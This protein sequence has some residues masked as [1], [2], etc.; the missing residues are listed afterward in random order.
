MM[1]LIQE[2]SFT[3]KANRQKLSAPTHVLFLF[4]ALTSSIVKAGTITVENGGVVQGSGTIVSDVIV[5]SGGSLNP[6]QS[7]GCLAMNNLDYSGGGTL[8]AEIGGDTA[9]TGYD[10]LRVTGTVALGAILD[11]SAYNS[12]VPVA[13]DSYQII[14]NDGADSVTGIFT[15]LEEGDV[16]T[17]SGKNLSISY[18]GGDGNDVVL[19]A[20]SDQTITFP[21]PAD[22]TYDVGSINVAATATSGLSVS[23]S[24]NSLSICSVSGST[25]SILNVGTCSITA[26]QS[27]NASYNAAVNVTQTFTVNKADQTISFGA[28]ANKTYGDA[29]FALGASSNSGLTVSFSSTTSSVCSVSGTTLS[30]VGAGSCSITASQEGDSNYNAATDVTQSFTINKANQSINFA[31]LVDK[32]FGDAAFGISASSDSG[33]AVSFVS[34]TTSVCSVSGSIVSIV[35]AGDCSITASQSGD[36]NYNAAT[37]MVQSFTVNKAEQSISFTTLAD[38][39]YGDADFSISAS[40]SSG[41]AVAFASTTNEVCTVTGSTVS[42]LAAGSCSISANQAGNTNYNAA[43]EV[44]QTFVVNK[45]DQSISFTALVDKTFGDASFAIS[46]SSDSGLA[47]S[48]VSTTTS[49]CTLSG[50]TV[51]IVAAGSCSITASQAGNTNYNAATNVAQSF[52]VN[53]ASQSISFAAIAGREFSEGGF[54]LVASADSG[55]AVSF[56]SS[57]P[58]VCTVSGSRVSLVYIG[59]C[60][61]SASQAGDGNYLAATDVVRSFNVAGDDTDGDGIPNDVDTDDDND[62]VED[63]EDAFPLDSTESVDTDGDGIGNNADTDDDNDGVLDEEDTFPLDETEWQDSDG[64]GIGDNSDDTPYPY[65]GD[66]NFEFTDYVVA[67]NGTSVEVKVTRTNGDYEELS[68]D[69]ALQDGTNPD[70]SATATNDYEFA[71]GTL[72]F[73]DGEVEQSVRINIVDDSTYEGDESFTISLSNL[74]SVGDSTIGS[75]AI[76]TITIQEDDAVPPAGEIGFEFDTELV[77]ENDGSFAIKVVRTGGSYGEVSVVLATQDDSAVAISD[78]TA[79]SQTLT[80]A[81]GETEKDVTINLVDDEVYESDESFRVTLSNVTGGATLGTSSTTVTILDDEPLPPSGVLGMENASYQVNE[82]DVSFEVT[83]VRSGGSFGEVSADIVSRNDSAIAGE[84][85]QGVNQPLTFADGEVTKTITVNLMD[86]STYEGDETFSLQLANAV[87]TELN[88]QMLSTVTIIEDDAVPP[89]GVIQFSGA[90]YAM[91][92]AGGDLTVTVTR[93]NGSFGEVTVDLAVTGGTAI[94]GVD[95]RIADSQLTFFDGDVSKTVSILVLDDSDYEGEENFVLE[96]THLTGDASLGS[97]NQTTITIEENDPVPA[98]GNIQLSGNAFSISE[99]F[100]ELTVTVIRTNGNYGD[101]S[102]DYQFIDSTAING[103]DFN[104]TNGTLYFA[105]GETSQTLVIDIVDDSRDENNES[106]SIELSNPVNTTI[107]GEAGAT[108]TINDNDEA[109]EEEQ[110]QNSSSGGG[111]IYWL[112]LACLLLINRRRA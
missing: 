69:Y 54:D 51:S 31:S 39:T 34:T 18:T 94:H 73:A 15:G 49:V 57:T 20:L 13:G 62:G 10:Q 111:A 108:V 37:N 81:D 88:N 79:L 104:A 87:G 109:V 74:H 53:Q 75:V 82:N 91:S 40:S 5:N 45:A 80:F 26:S 98:S 41:L 35:S 50:S 27:G 110:G 17:L 11:L 92:E 95:Y 106:F 84:D 23:F 7:P 60:T 77:N 44:A 112:L 63:S 32:T 8:T 78:Y 16:L 83:I 61:I 58:S 3:T 52:T 21:A 100:S 56:A 68:V 28:L 103:E 105:D 85:Y 55:L 19:T 33:L 67:E 97:V 9:C 36:S 66:I 59:E 96:L 29:D 46:A 71:A 6:G 1:K 22:Q 30:I 42:I 64:D 86:D 24:S 48:F 99:S 12:F 102:V 2:G 43:A 93:T 65:S 47:V 101:I 76:A 72:T 89:A 14:D 38:K 70:S 4:L 25:V 107:A 90:A